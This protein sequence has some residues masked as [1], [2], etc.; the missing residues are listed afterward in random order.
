[1]AGIKE[2]PRQK[3]IGMMYL[4][5]TALLALQ[6][7][8]AVI[9][10]FQTL[11][12]SIEATI[13]DMNSASF[14]KLASIIA[15]VEKRGNAERE[16]KLRDDA[17]DISLECK[18]TQEYIS[19]LKQE[20]IEVSGGYDADGNLKG[21]KEE[22]EV[23]VLMIGANK[24]GKGY[25]LKKKLDHLVSQ[26][27]NATGKTFPYLA[28]NG[29]EDS[30][31]KNNKEQKGKDFAELNFG[32]TPLAA[33]LAILSELQAKVSGME[34]KVLVSISDS[35]G[36]N[37]WTFD[38]VMPV[39]KAGNKYVAA[40]RPYEA[41][42][43][44]TA[45]SNKL[46]PK[47]SIEEKNLPV[48]AD[49]RGRYTFTTSGG[50]YG[51]DGTAKKSWTG[52]I[53]MTKPDGQDTTFTVREE[54]YVTQPIIQIQSASVQSLYRNC[55]NKLNIQVPAL[56]EYYSPSITATGAKVINSG[57]KG[58]VTVVPNGHRTTIKVSSN[59]SYIGEQEYGVKSIPKPDIK[60]MFN[61]KTNTRNGIS[62]NDLKTIMVKAIPDPDFQ[63]FLP[64]DSEYKITEWNIDIKRVKRSA[65]NGQIDV[66][67]SEI[68]TLG[69]MLSQ[70]QEG[71][72]AIVEVIKVMRKNFL[73]Q[74]EEVSM[75]RIIETALIH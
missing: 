68:K 12:K 28:L 2:T 47:I 60:I 21:A 55:G 72:V 66:K 57:N 26:I 43:F 70:I 38:K 31:F 46:K 64:N 61:G 35:I 14:V 27:N 32:Q 30:F 15:A 1:M 48:N 65:L 23:E 74:W 42:I 39:V 7:S 17:K 73:G 56:G 22:T 20:L 10:K 29:S 9:F 54:Y 6:V 24:D 19:K 62:K 49:G 36:I 37:D 63:A 45:I 53:T 16:V 33:A 59:G 13:Q 44:M 52:K 67:N 34:N 69:N 51:P 18:E 3:M 40:G 4:V 25:E 11:N 71:D 50:N 8:S 75:P 58:F 41:E 5:L